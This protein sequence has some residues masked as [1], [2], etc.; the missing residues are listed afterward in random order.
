MKLLILLL[1]LSIPFIYQAQTG[2]L[3]TESFTFDSQTREYLLYVPDT[4]DG[5]TDVP[6]VLNLHGYTSNMTQQL[7]YGEFRKIADTANFILVVPNGL[8]DNSGNQHWNYYQPNGVDDL[9]FL[10]ALIDT[11]TT[12]YSINSNRVYTTGMSN[13]GFMSIALGCQLSSK[14]AAVAS[15]TG[16]MIT[17]QASSCLPIHPVPTMLIHGTNDPT[18]PYAGNATFKSVEETVQF[19]VDQTG[20]DNTPA[21]NSVPDVNTIDGCTAE[22]YVYEN[23]DYG[24]S[25]EHY[26]II[27]GGHTWPGAAFNIG[28]TNQDFDAST[29]IWRFFSQYDKEQL[30]AVSEEEMKQPTV[31]VYPNPTPDKVQVSTDKIIQQITVYDA[32]G[33]QVY[34]AQPQQNQAIIHD[35]ESGMY[36]VQIELGNGVVNRKVIIE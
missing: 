1:T 30:L 4:Y 25:V 23:G 27:G 10:S 13:G 36:T 8:N 33:K 2:T 16:T 21:V 26:K 14:I 22:H 35:L 11:M 28:V 20:S 29:Q 32:V 12:N 24:S 3:T 7:N 19:W 15:V 18:V 17:G 31:H 9:G 6:L 5:Q 34:Q